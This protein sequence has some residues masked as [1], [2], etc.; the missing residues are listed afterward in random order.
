MNSARRSFWHEFIRLS[1][2]RSANWAA[3]NSGLVVVGLAPL[4]AW[5]RGDIGQQPFYLMLLVFML[6]GWSMGFLLSE[7]VSQFFPQPRISVRIT[8]GL[9]GGVLGSL[10]FWYMT[11][12]SGY[13]SS[14]LY[15]MGFGCGA[16]VGGCVLSSYWFK[17][18]QRLNKVET[19]QD[20]PTNH[21]DHIR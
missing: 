6:F 20:L 2:V 4:F 9:I 14:W 16:A 19:L 7:A 13:V 8:F 3:F 5:L 21:P 15:I 17:A 10:G 1:Q 11:V 18:V 12:G